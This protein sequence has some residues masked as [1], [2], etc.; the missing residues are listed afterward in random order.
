MS[1]SLLS[2]FAW[3]PLSALAL[4]CGDAGPELGELTDAEA[5]SLLA[6]LSVIWFPSPSAPS[7]APQGP[8]LVPQTTLIQD[9]TAYTVSCGGGGTAAVS[10]IDSL[11]ITV[12]ARINPS[13][14][15]TYAS[16]TDYGGTSV[17]TVA[18]AGCGSTAG[19]GGTWV[20][21]A[22]PGLTFTYDIEGTIDSYALTGQNAV[23]STTVDWS[24]LWSGSFN[25]SNG[26]RSG[27]CT[28]SLTSTAETSNIGGQIT[29][30]FTQQGQICGIDVST[31]S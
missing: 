6:A 25:W 22:A 4:G 12:D 31:Q 16:N 11:S 23:I 24:G 7:P 10:S 2:R 8:L 5:S 20:F 3:V 18:Y 29:S 28:I 30:T 19:Q 9:T 1:R 21:D 27:S 15:T 13:P 17:T 14:D 26:S